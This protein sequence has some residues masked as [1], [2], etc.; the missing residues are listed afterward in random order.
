LQRVLIHPPGGALELEVDLIGAERTG[1]PLLVFLH[2][3]LGSL[4]GWGNWPRR[5]CDAAGCR[6]LVFSRYGY[7]RSQ[8]RPRHQDW[9]TNYLEIEAHEH[10]PALFEALAIDPARDAPILFGH[11]DGGT[12]ALQYAAAFPDAAGGIVVLAPH[13]FAEE[14]ARARI[15]QL[16]QGWRDGRLRD[17]LTQWHDDPAGVFMGW[18][19]CWLAPEF[20]G[21]TIS[22]TL[23]AIRCPAL[24]VQG[25]LDQYGT[26][27]QL[28]E[29]RRKV[30]H[31]ELLV[32]DECR[33]VPHEEQPGAV[34]EAVLGFLSRLSPGTRKREQR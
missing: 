5:L 7:G 30:P 24:A 33:H 4:D 29:L 15:E 25:A 31:A 21:W 26:V 34:R 12:I 32:L 3:G 17:W 16:R 20:R 11:S 2:E 22:G 13:L 23:S 19:G 14:I 28:A 1:A 9:P 18:S 6:G 8:V 27:E 10:L